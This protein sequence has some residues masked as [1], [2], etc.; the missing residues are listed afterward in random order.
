MTTLII[1]GSSEGERRCDARCHSAEGP[2]CDCIC[3]GRF[4]GKANT[5]GALEQAKEEFKDQILAK[6]REENPGLY[7]QLCADLGQPSLPV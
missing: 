2:E 5:P 7:I 3:S 1:Y 4:H 6:L